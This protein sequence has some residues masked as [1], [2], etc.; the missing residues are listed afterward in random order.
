MKIAQLEKERK[1]ITMA[2]RIENIQYAEENL[3]QWWQEKVFKLHPE[4]F[5]SLFTLKTA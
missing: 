5:T 2:V 3:D 1:K 4:I